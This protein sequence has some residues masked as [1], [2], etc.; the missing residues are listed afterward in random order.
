MTTTRGTSKGGNELIIQL[1]DF[2]RGT[3]EKVDRQDIKLDIIMTKVIFI[4]KVIIFSI[5]NY[6]LFLSLRNWSMK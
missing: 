6:L 3:D 1:S 5:I 2:V 4:M